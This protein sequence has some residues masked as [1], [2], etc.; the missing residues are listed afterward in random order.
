MPGQKEEQKKVYPRQAMLI[1]ATRCTGCRACAI[2]CAEWYE[3]GPPGGFGYHYCEDFGPDTLVKITDH[4]SM[5]V[6][7]V[8]WM[9]APLLCMHCSYAPCLA[10]CPVPGALERDPVSGNT[11]VLDES[12]CIHCLY[13]TYACAFN[14]LRPG[15][16]GEGK[17]ILSKCNRCVERTRIGSPEVPACVASCP[18]GA[19]VFGK[20]IEEIIAEKERRLAAVKKTGKRDRISYGEGYLGGLG[21]IYIFDSD[22][23]RDYFLTGWPRYTRAVWTWQSVLKPAALIAG[24]VALVIMLFHRMLIGPLG[25]K[26][27]EAA[28]EKEL[29]DEELERMIKMKRQEGKMKAMGAEKRLMR[30]IKKKGKR[31]FGPKGQSKH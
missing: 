5:T 27:V 4:E 10:V 24:I 9:T 7:G 22:D 6:D 8:K 28:E 26:I 13:C 25:V 21:V 1:D 23:S 29:T 19:L 3:W 30:K 15:T 2:A 20:A 11:I 17:Y 14:L 31:P 12:R 16:E 18:T